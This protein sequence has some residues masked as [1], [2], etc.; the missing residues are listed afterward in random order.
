[1]DK[2]FE[3]ISRQLDGLVS[4][5][6]KLTGYVGSVTFSYEEQELIRRVVKSVFSQM[7][8]KNDKENARS[9]LIKT[10]WLNGF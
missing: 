8:S 3:N 9:I 4:E 1:M 2:K 7:K 5:A 10:E 6:K